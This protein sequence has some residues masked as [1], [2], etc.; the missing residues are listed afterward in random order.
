M[1]HFTD[2]QGISG[3]AL[4]FTDIQGH[5]RPSERV[6]SA[7]GI[8]GT[9]PHFTDIQGHLRPSKLKNFQVLPMNL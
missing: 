8:S 3:T 7:Q 9:A 6:F 2:L 4:H 1:L 5:L